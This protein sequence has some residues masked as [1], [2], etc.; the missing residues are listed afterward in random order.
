MRY[1]TK[2]Q[3]PQ[4]FT[5]DT[6]DLSVWDEYMKKRTLKKYLLKEEQN[7]LCGYCEAKVTLDNSHL[8]HIKPRHLDDSLIFDYN[9]LLVSCNGVCFSEKNQQV[10]CGHKKGADFDEVKFLNPTKI[11]NIRDY[12]IYTDKFMIKSSDLDKEKAQYTLQLLQLNTFN[13]YLPEARKIALEEFQK[14]AMAYVEKT[15]KDMKEVVKILL[16]KE[17]LAFISFLRFR[18]KAIL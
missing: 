11:K 15:K 9:N 5:D 2:S 4:F 16:N 12:F 7:Y 3:I 10:T 17:N 1:I 13:N 18:H 14:S 6:L 8:E